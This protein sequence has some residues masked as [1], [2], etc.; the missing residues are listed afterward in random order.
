MSSLDII[1]ISNENSKNNFLNFRQKINIGK[2]SVLKNYSLD[3]NPTS[4]IKYSL[5]ILT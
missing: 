4:N 1:N 5:K 3:I 2:N